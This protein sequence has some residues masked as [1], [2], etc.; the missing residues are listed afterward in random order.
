M[1]TKRLLQSATVAELERALEARKLAGQQRLKELL[2]QRAALDREIATLQGTKVGRPKKTK[3]K[4]NPKK[5]AKR[6]PVG[7]RQRNGKPTIKSLAADVLR[8]AKKP[9]HQNEIAKLL[10]E[11]KG[12]KSKSKRFPMTLGI[13]LGKD[14]RFKRVARATYTLK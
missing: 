1:S 5:P 10:I 9:L 2:A 14:S 12:V 3:A 13:Q 4:A 7:F 11:K 8:S 6:A